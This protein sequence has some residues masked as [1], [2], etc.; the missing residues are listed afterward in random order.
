VSYKERKEVAS[1]LKNIYK[2][3]NEEAALEELSAF[4]AK[5]NTKYPQIGKS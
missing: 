5:W 3:P 1:D 2:A 4:E